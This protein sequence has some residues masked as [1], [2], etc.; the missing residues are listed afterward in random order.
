MEISNIRKSIKRYY[1][2]SDSS[3]DELSRHFRMHEFPARHL[4]IQSNFIDRNVYFIERG[5]T[6]S[7]CI[8]NGKEHTTWFSKEGDITF[9]L[10]CLYHNQRGFENVETVEP[11]LAYS[12]PIQTL[13]QLYETNI[14]IANWGRVIHQECLLAIQCVRIDNLTMSAKERYEQLLMRFPDICKRVNLGYIASFLGISLSTLSR[15]RS[16]I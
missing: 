2:V 12:I 16:E 5:I 6:R 1:P 7:Y 14:E 4:I 15:I 3:I 8:V 10:L 11:T 9:G 13:N